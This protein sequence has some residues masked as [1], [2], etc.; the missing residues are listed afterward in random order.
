MVIKTEGRHDL[1]IC[2]KCGG[3]RF[4]VRVIRDQ[5]WLVDEN[6]NKLLVECSN[7]ISDFDNGE[8]ICAECGHVGNATT[9]EAKKSEF[10]VTITYSASKTFH[11]EAYD[12]ENAVDVA[13][14]QLDSEE[15]PISYVVE[16]E[17][18]VIEEG[19]F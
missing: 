16:D 17:D 13:S 19:V 5:S 4:I 11:V 3:K 8:L 6:G 1:K 18:G 9:F 7:L 15:L 10:D 12:Y 14:E 2:P